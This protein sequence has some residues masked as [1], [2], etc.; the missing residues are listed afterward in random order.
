[1][2]FMLLARSRTFV[3]RTVLGAIFAGALSAAAFNSGV[4]QEAAPNTKPAAGGELCPAGAPDTDGD[5]LCDAAENSYGTDPKK[6]DTDGD[7]LSD[8]AE[9]F[10]VEFENLTVEGKQFLDLP[11]LGANPLRRDVFVEIDY[12]PGHKPRTDALER[13]VKAF[14]AAPLE[15]PDRSKGIDLHYIIDNEIDPADVVA[16]LGGSPDGEVVIGAELPFFTY[17]EFEKIKLKYVDTVRHS[18]FHYALYADTM[19]HGAAS[20][21]SFHI[22]G[23]DFVLAMGAEPTLEQ[24]AG[25]FMHELGHNLGLRHGGHEDTN[26][27]PNYLSVMNYVY[28]FGL[29]R[30]GVNTLD[31]SRHPV[32]AMSEW[33]VDEPAGLQPAIGTTQDDLKRYSLLAFD[34]LTKLADDASSSVDWN[35]N[36]VIETEPYQA[37]LD[38]DHWSENDFSASQNDWLALDF[39]GRGSIGIEVDA[40][41]P[42]VNVDANPTNPACMFPIRK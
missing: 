4:A 37:D 40:P 27:K 32:L 16:D 25:T 31:Y 10:G 12:Y 30:D 21:L 35:Q 42:D 1:M 6:A 5:S 23:H 39:G 13:V 9:L 18:A 33:R 8:A 19:L 3:Q 11:G 26:Y 15:N 24:E 41:K 2:D 7:A 22:T 34:G 20:G 38:G 36:G 14:A 29:I 17:Q 28:S